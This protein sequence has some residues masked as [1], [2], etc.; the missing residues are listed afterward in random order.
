MKMGLRLLVSCLC[1]VGTQATVYSADTTLRGSFAGQCGVVE[2]VISGITYEYDAY[3][4]GESSGYV[5]R[6]SFEINVKGA[7][8][9]VVL[10]S[11]PFQKSTDSLLYSLRTPFKILYR[12][13]FVPLG[14]DEIYPGTYFCLR[15][16]SGE[17][18]F[19]TEPFLSTDYLSDYDKDK[20]LASIEKTQIDAQ[21]SIKYVPGGLTIVPY[22]EESIG[23]AL[24]TISGIGICDI[25]GITEARSITGL[26][27]GIYLLRLNISTG[28]V[29]HKISIR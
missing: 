12:D 26:P 14:Y 24:F 5:G 20:Y 29:L 21:Y 16:H 10:K 25:E 19:Q 8:D 7:S 28:P 23:L 27:P 2:Y 11:K 1:F 17:E 3:S 15:I 4:D 13:E 18:T 9:C 22:G 6:F